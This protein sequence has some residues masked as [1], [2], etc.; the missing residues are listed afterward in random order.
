MEK[1]YQD[2]WNVNFPVNSCQWL[3]RDVV[4]ISKTPFFMF[5]RHCEGAV[6][7]VVVVR[8]IYIYLVLFIE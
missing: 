1:Y 2:W 8:D 7:V 6:I 4:E 3:K 5:I